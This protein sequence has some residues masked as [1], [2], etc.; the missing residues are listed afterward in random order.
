MP[1]RKKRNSQKRKS[2]ATLPVLRPNVAGIDIGSRSHLVAG[3]VPA[4]GSLNVKEFGTTTPDLEALID[5]LHEQKVESVA[6]ESTSVYWIPLY[7][8]LEHNGIEVLLVNARQISHV[9]G[10]KTD[11]LDCQWIQLLHSCGLLRGSF[12]PDEAICALRALKRQWSNLVEERTKAVQWMQKA[13]DQMNVQVHRAVSELTGKTGMSIVRAIVD[14]ERD[15]LKL[16]E[17]RDKR[18]KKSL[19]EIA[20]HLTGTWREEHVFNLGMALRFYDHIQEMIEAYDNRLIDKIEKLQSPERKEESVPVHPNPK[21]E[22]AIRQRG[23]QEMRTALWR[24]ADVDLARID[25]V[26]SGA[27]QLIITEIGLDLS[28]FPNEKKFVAWLRL[29][30]QHGISGGKP[31]KGKKNSMGATRIATAL[32]MAALSLNRSNTALGAYY[33]RISRRRGAA[34]AIFATARKLATLIYR[35]LRFGQDYVDIGEQAYEDRFKTRRLAALKSS[36][37]SLGYLLVPKKEV[38]QVSG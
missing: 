21:K 23:E 11:V 16:A 4:D 30:P 15:P 10:R 35:M 36:A 34:V 9:P 32:R 1:K 8:L 14:G 22:K 19:S 28:N 25:G 5:W 20:D 24:L 3:P 27:A 17:H 29:S 31:L 26:S 18:C 6:M 33:R 38:I 37:F 2:V 7:E 12:R 13:L